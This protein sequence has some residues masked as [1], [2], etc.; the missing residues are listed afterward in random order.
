MALL[1]DASVLDSNMEYVRRDVTCL[2]IRIPAFVMVS[3]EYEIYCV[4]V[5]WRTMCLMRR[6]G[7]RVL[8]IKELYP[9][10]L[11]HLFNIHPPILWIT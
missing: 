5:S 10:H 7:K 8:Q 3:G 11:N 4:N 9:E 2:T 6:R 1:P